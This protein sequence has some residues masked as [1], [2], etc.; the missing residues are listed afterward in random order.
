VRVVSGLAVVVVLAAP[1]FALA[2]D[3]KVQ[4]GMKLFETQKCGICHSVAGKGSKRSPLDGVGKKLTEAQVREWLTDPASAA[5]KANSTIKPPMLSY[6]KLPATD[7]DAL[8][9]Y[10]MSLK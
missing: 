9:A 5:K 7:V 6:S 4:Q 1:G 2:Q 3:A 10:M 8:V